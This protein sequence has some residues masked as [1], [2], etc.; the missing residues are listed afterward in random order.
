MDGLF[1]S[2]MSPWLPLLSGVAAMAREFVFS[3]FE[4]EKFF[5]IKGNAT[6]ENFLYSSWRWPWDFRLPSMK[7]DRVAM[8]EEQN[9]TTLV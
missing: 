2:G 9:K 5:L 3:V 8:G 4:E 7:T 6:K 1:V